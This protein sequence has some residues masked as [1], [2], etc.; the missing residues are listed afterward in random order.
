[1]GQNQSPVAKKETAQIC[2][3][4]ENVKVCPFFVFI[5]NEIFVQVYVN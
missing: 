1:M 2:I 5:K 3:L 4:S